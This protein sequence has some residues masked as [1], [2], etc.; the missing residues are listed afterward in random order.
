MEGLIFI[1]LVPSLTDGT[2]DFQQ[3]PN[4]LIRVV[5]IIQGTDFVLLFDWQNLTIGIL[6]Y[7]N[8]GGLPQYTLCLPRTAVRVKLYAPWLGL[9]HQKNHNYLNFEIICTHVNR[10]IGLGTGIWYR[11]RTEYSLQKVPVYIVSRKYCTST[12]SVPY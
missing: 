4:Q 8:C 11:I 2:V 7:L 5:D 9:N 1:T 12:L 10:E 3:S 6:Y